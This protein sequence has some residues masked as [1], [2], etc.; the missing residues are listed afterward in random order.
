MYVSII[1]ISKRM[2][3]N[4]IFKRDAGNTLCVRVTRAVYI[5]Q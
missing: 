3:N 2:G 5:I 1:D 4:I